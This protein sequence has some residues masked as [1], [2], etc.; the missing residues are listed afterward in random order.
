MLAP[1][2]EIVVTEMEHHAN[3]VPWQ[4]LCAKTGAML[5]WIGLTDE[6]GLISSDLDD[7]RQ[8][9]NQVSSRSSTNSNILGTINP[10]ATDSATALS[11]RRCVWW[12]STPASRSRIC[13]STCETL[14]VDFVAC[15]GHKMLGPTGIGVLW[16]R[17]ELLDAMP[18]F[19]HRRLDD[20]VGHMERIDVRTS[21]LSDSRRE[22]PMTAQ[23]VGLAA[24]VDYLDD[25]GMDRGRCP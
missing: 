8:R 12:C 17:A 3:L 2:D 4:E 16:G 22:V 10:V 13:R 19:S 18:P 20:R 21:R 7:D 24:A 25:L 23:A 9:P 5:R 6:G 1:G 15:S 14:G 11:A